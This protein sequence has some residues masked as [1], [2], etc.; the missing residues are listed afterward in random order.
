MLFSVLA[1]EIFEKILIFSKSNVFFPAVA[2]KICEKIQIFFLTY[3]FFLLTVTNNKKA[4]ANTKTDRK[5]WK[6]LSYMG[7][8][9][10]VSVS[11]LLSELYGF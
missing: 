9:E 4:F 10:S 2:A 1:A 6:I 3:T 11:C 8:F 7:F 5:K